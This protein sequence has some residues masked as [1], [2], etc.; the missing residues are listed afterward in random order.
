LGEAAEALSTREGTA[1]RFL[2]DPE[3][4]ESLVLTSERLQ[5]TF[6]ELHDLLRQWQEK[7]LKLEGGVFGQ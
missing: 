1:G 6:V 3:L 7:G 5:Q 4:Y 2:N